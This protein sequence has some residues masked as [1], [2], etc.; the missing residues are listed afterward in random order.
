M[1]GFLLGC[2]HEGIVRALALTDKDASAVHCKKAVETLSS[3]EDPQ[4]A[5][6]LRSDLASI[7][8]G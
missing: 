6:I 1:K 7:D 3:I 2:A 4:D 5:E 8:L